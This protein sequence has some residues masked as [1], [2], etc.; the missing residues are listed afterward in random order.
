MEAAPEPFDASPLMPTR[1]RFSA[2]RCQV[3]Q[4]QR[5]RYA[6]YPVA[7]LGDMT[8]GRMPT[9]GKGSAPWTYQL[10][11]CLKCRNSGM[12]TSSRDPSS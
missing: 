1:A 5:A 8:L 2:C 10:I 7:V 9:L 11:P 6:Q 12:Q 3:I 4:E